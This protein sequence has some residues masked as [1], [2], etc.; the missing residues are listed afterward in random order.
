MTCFQDLPVGAHFVW[1]LTGDECEK[2]DPDLIDH[3]EAGFERCYNAMSL[4]ERRQ[5][6]IGDD[7]PVE[8]IALPAT[9]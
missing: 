6:M 5:I 9:R 1:E 2:C 3:D 7:E 4:A 8:I